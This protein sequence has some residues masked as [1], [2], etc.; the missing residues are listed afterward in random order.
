MS[1][2]LDSLTDAKLSEV[3]AVEVAGWARDGSALSPLR[4][5]DAAGE[6]PWDYENDKLGQPKF[7]T[8]ADAVMPFLEGSGCWRAYREKHGQGVL[9]SVGLIK[10]AIGFSHT[11]AR[12]V[13]IALI[14]AKRAQS[15]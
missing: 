11:F 10:P 2:E 5:K 12:A 7:A 14:R 3:F 4:W 9:I 15:S 6:M 1:Y 13:C 8:S